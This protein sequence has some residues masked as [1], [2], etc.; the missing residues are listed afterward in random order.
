VT[1][2]PTVRRQRTALMLA[3]NLTVL[4]AVGGLLYTGGKALARYRGAK[5]TTVT[6]IPIPVTPVG[7]L[8]TVDVKNHLTSVTVMV[9]KPNGHGGGSVVNIP[10]NADTSGVEGQR[11]SLSEAYVQGGPDGLSQAVESILTVTIDQHAVLGPDQFTSVLSPIASFQVTF[12]TKVATTDK[13]GN[14]VTLYPKGAQTLTAKQMTIAMNAR[15]N[16]QPESARQPT[17]LALWSAI[18]AANGQGRGIPTSVVPANMNDVFAQLFSGQLLTRTIPVLALPASEATDKDVALLDRA[19]AVFVFATIAP[20][21]MSAANTGLTFRIEAP[22]G[23][24]DKVRFVVS[25]LLY[26]DCNVQWVYANGPVHADT[27]VFLKDPAISTQVTGP[28]AVLGPTVTND[29][30]YRIEGIDVIVQLG[31]DFLA[32]TAPTTLPATTTIAVTP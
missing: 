22:P 25:A 12:P 2:L 5:N 13:S 3:L 1:S 18:A 4:V 29:P 8:A 32:S 15:V 23:Y 31:T 27:Q 7:M 14:T 11:V 21:N 9:E 26:L 17:I 16:G 10:L 28:L 30:T 6:T 24:D 19:D 20:S